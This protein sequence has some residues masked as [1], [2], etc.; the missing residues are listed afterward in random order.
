M[1]YLLS[2]L[3][4]VV[5][6]G[7]SSHRNSVYELTKQQETDL[8]TVASVLR[9]IDFNGS[10]SVNSREI[11]NSSAEIVA[12][13]IP[14]TVFKLCIRNTFTRIVVEPEFVYYV[15]DGFKGTNYGLL[16]SNIPKDSLKGF[17]DVQLLRISN[18]PKHYWYFVSSKLY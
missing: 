3:L 18:S 16:Y 14:D 10:I 13:T 8:M 1:K 12:Q 15:I 7:C 9:Q 5:V 6:H 11:R 2:I 17:Y 4:I